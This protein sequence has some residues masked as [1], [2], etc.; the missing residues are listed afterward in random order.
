MKAPAPTPFLA[1]PSATFLGALSR[2]RGRRIFHPHGVGFEGE[3]I[4]QAE[5][6]TGSELFD[7]PRPSPA[8]AR[9]S[10]SLGLPEVLP[11]PCGLAIRIPDA[12]GG[13]LHQD[14]LLVTSGR[15]PLVRQLVLPSQGFADRWYSSLLPYGIGGHRAL[16][17]ARPA[18]RASGLTLA[19]L[20]DRDSAELD[21]ELGLTSPLG[22]WRR[23]AVLRLGKRLPADRVEELDFSPVHTGGGL[24]PIGFFNRLRPPAYVASQEGR[25]EA[26]AR[27]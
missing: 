2:L 23:V 6:P 17:G 25:R 19:E 14:F 10:R 26:E 9:L 21:F 3:L 20:R 15:R 7:R 11:D 27:R 18:A 1:G 4:P 22:H 12:Y 24:E 8:I 5:V 13:G 16:V